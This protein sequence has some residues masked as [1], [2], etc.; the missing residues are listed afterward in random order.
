MREVASFKLVRRQR[1]ERIEGERR[2]D[3]ILNEIIQKQHLI[4][5]AKG[6]RRKNKNRVNSQSYSTVYTDSSAKG[7]LSQ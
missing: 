2:V 7:R 6:P 1:H 4:A 5:A 3:Q